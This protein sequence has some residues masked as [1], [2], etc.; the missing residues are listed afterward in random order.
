VE[1]FEY[2]LAARANDDRPF[3]IYLT[4]ETGTPGDNKAHRDKL[5]AALNS[6]SADDPRVTVVYR[7]PGD[8]SVVVNLGTEVE[9]PAVE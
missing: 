5:V 7:Q 1:T 2:L 8:P 4:N 3:T 6:M 9:L